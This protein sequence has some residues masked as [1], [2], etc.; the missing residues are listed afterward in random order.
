MLTPPPTLL[1]LLNSVRDMMTQ[2]GILEVSIKNGV[3]ETQ[4]LVIETY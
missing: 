3:I 4:R 1:S 2:T